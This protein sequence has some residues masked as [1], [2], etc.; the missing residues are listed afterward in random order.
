MQTKSVVIEKLQ[1]HPEVHRLAKR[2][3]KVDGAYLYDPS[4]V[5]GDDERDFCGECG[6]YLARH[7]R[8]K[9][10][11]RNDRHE[12]YPC[13]LRREF[14]GSQQDGVRYCE[15][16]GVRLDYPFTDHCA[17]QLLWGMENESAPSAESP[18]D[19]DIMLMLA[20]HAEAAEQDFVSRFEAVADHYLRQFPPGMEAAHA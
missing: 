15:F 11:K 19:A 12:G 1:A 6:Y 18:E 8:R 20:D 5:H 13:E 14:D 16:C 7:L 10:R 4:G 3:R 17:E 2:H 9:Y